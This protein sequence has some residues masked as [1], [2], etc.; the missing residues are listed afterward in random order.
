MIR[1]AAILLVASSCS[2]PTATANAGQDASF[3]SASSTANTGHVDVF[4]KTE[5]MA[6]IWE[7]NMAFRST[8]MTVSEGVCIIGP[9][10][11]AP[12][13]SGGAISIV[14]PGMPLALMPRTDFSY[15]D[16]GNGTLWSGADQKLTVSSTGAS[17]G[18]PPFEA[19]V[20]TP[21]QITIKT[22]AM[23][24]GSALT[25]T[26]T[27]PFNVTWTPGSGTLQIT[28]TGF[29]SSA[30][31]VRCE[32]PAETGTATIPPSALMY[33]PG[34][35]GSIDVR[36]LRRTRVSKPDWTVD[37]VASTPALTVGEPATGYVAIK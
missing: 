30:R 8:P 22:P 24:R 23:I 34:P 32:Y 25:I 18:A 11:E 14:T 5:A 20:T 9:L 6:Q 27:V 10:F 4:Q 33:L 37:V 19:E 35:D 15:H 36:S 12:Y 31:E 2:S 1:F 26:R 13:V 21:P 7:V 3:D 29:A 17:S 16:M 28:L